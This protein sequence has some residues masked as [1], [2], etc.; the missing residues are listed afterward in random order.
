MKRGTTIKRID[1]DTLTLERKMVTRSHVLKVHRERCMGCD[2]C[3]AVCPREAIELLPTVLEAGKLV[4]RPG[5][6]IKP[7]KCQFC[8]ECVVVCP[9]N[10]LSMLVDGEACV[11][12]WQYEVFP[13]LTKQIHIDATCLPV[14]EAEATEKC[15]PTHVIAVEVQRDSAG[16]PVAVQDVRVDESNCIYCKQCEALAPQVFQVTSPFEGLIRLES[17]LCPAGCQVCADTC[18]SHALTMV[19]GKLALDD[20][21]CLYCGACAQVCPVPAAL[22]VSRHR[23]RHSPIKSGAWV[24]ALEKLVSTE[25][26]AEELALK[27]QAKR[28]SV[29]SFMPGAPKKA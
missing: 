9:A 29:L 15:C 1:P 28:R 11:P 26:A 7:E 16:N 25:E 18:P 3:V 5:V 23:V 22:H 4:Q 13:T 24:A 19:D 17:S 8:G 27:S 2:L 21:F 14:S 10:A 6:D 20:R 12:V